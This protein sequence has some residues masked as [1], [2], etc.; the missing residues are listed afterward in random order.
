MI[1]EKITKENLYIYYNSLISIN[2]SSET[3]QN[4]YS[5]YLLRI[6]NLEQTLLLKKCLMPLSDFFDLKES[7]F[8]IREIEENKEDPEKKLLNKYNT[9]KDMINNSEESNKNK[10]LNYNDKFFLQHMLSKKYISIETLPGNNNYNLKLTSN[11]DSAVPFMLKRI[12]ETRKSQEFLT[13]KQSFYMKIY[14]KDKDDDYYINSKTFFIKKSPEYDVDSLLLGQNNLYASNENII[15]NR[16]NKNNINII[17]NNEDKDYDPDNNFINFYENFSELSIDL[18]MNSKY[19]F[20]NQSWYLKYQDKLFSSHIINIIFINSNLYRDTNKNNLVTE[21]EEQLM[22]SAEYIESQ[23]EEEILEQN[24]VPLDSN[25]I[26]IKKKKD[27]LFYY[28]EGKGLISKS[29]NK[30]NLMENQIRVKLV[31]YEKDFYKHVLNNSFWVIEEE[32]NEHKE[33]LEKSP[34]MEG[35]QIKIKNVLLGLYLKVKK[36]GNE[37]EIEEMSNNGDENNINEK[38]NKSLENK[39]EEDE[40]EFELVDEETL[41]KNNFFFSNFKIFHYSISENS[42]Y[43][44]YKGKYALRNIFKDDKKAIDNFDFQELNKYFQPLSINLD[45]EKKYFLLP[46]NED[47]YIF[48]IKKIDI[49]EANHVIYMNKIIKNLDFYLDKCIS[50]EILVNSAIKTINLNLSFF[51]NYLINVEY[52]FRDEN[53]DINEPIEQRQLILENYGVLKIIRKIAEY[54][55]PIARDLNSKKKDIYQTKKYNYNKINNDTSSVFSSFSNNNASNTNKYRFATLN[56][57]IKNRNINI[58]NMKK[59]I[60]IILAFL[61]Y[62]SQDNEE[63][64]EKIFLDLD[65]ILELAEN[66]F[67]LDK[68]NLLNFIFK[69]IKHSEVLQEYITG[70]RLNLM[71]TIKNS[72]HYQNYAEKESQNKLIRMDKILLYIE[73]SNNY[74]YYYKKLLKLNKVKH[75]KEKIKQLIIEHMRKVENE[76][77]YKYNYKRNLINII[78][79]TKV[80]LKRIEEPLLNK[81]ENNYKLVEK[82]SDKNSLRNS[83]KSDNDISLLNSENSKKINISTSEE[84]SQKNENEI[85]TTKNA[86]TT[87]NDE[88][89]K[90]QRNEESLKCIKLFLSFFENF[91]INNTLFIQEKC[92]NEFFNSFNEIKNLKKDLNF[93]INGE[94]ESVQLI[95]GIK[96]DPNSGLGQLIPFNLFNKF[97]PKFRSRNINFNNFTNAL[98]DNIDDDSED[99]YYNVN[100]MYRINEEADNIDDNNINNNNIENNNMNHF[101]KIVT[102]SRTMKFNMQHNFNIRTMS[103]KNKKVRHSKTDPNIIK[104]QLTNFNIDDNLLK[105]IE[106]KQKDKDYIKLNKYLCILYTTYQFCINEYHESLL[107]VMN[108]LNNY[109]NNYES[110]CDMKVFENNLSKIKENLITKIAFI[111]NDVLTN[112]YSATKKK[113][114]TLLKGIFDFNNLLVPVKDIKKNKFDSNEDNLEFDAFLLDD[115]KNNK[116]ASNKI[117]DK[118]G[119]KKAYQSLSPEEITLVK[120]LFNFCKKYDKISYIMDK[121]YYFKRI[122]KLINNDLDRPLNQFKK[123]DTLNTNEI[124]TLIIKN[125]GKNIN[126]KSLD[127]NTKYFYIKEFYEIIKDLNEKRKK[128]LAAYLDI[129]NIKKFLSASL[130]NQNDN[131]LKNIKPTAFAYNITKRCDIIIRL[132]M[133]YEIDNI[134]GKLIYLDINHNP[135]YLESNILSNLKRVQNNF[136]EIKNEIKKIKIDFNRRGD[137]CF[138]IIKNENSGIINQITFNDSDFNKVHFEIVNNCLDKMSK[139]FINFLNIDSNGLFRLKNMS[140]LNKI[141]YKENEYFYKKIGFERIMQNLIESINCF[142]DFDRNPIIKLKYCQE[143]LR[144]FLDIQGVYKNFKEIIPTYFTL[145]YKMIIRSLHS[146]ILF[147]DNKI[148]KEEEKYFLKICYYCCESLMLIIFNSEKNFGEL[149]SFM[150]DVFSKLL[151]IYSHLKNPKYRIIFQIL[152]TYYISRVLLFISKEKN[153]DDFSYNSFFNNVYPMNKMKEQISSCIDEFEKNEEEESSEE[154]EESEEN[155]ESEGSREVSENQDNINNQNNNINN[156]KYNKKGIK[157]MNEMS[158]NSENSIKTNNYDET[159]VFWENDE[160]KE[161]FCFYLN[162]L[163]IYILYIHDRN[164]IKKLQENRSNEKSINSIEYNYKN[165]YSKIQKLLDNSTQQN[166]LK[167]QYF[168]TFKLS[169]LKTFNELSLK[170]KN[171]M[172][173]INQENY[174]KNIRNKKIKNNFQFESVLI[175][176]II[177]Y[178]YRLKNQNIEIAVKNR[179]IKRTNDEIISNAPSDDKTSS[180]DGKIMEL[181]NHDMITFYYYDNE[182]IDLILLEKICNDIN[183]GENLNFYCTEKNQINDFNIYKEDLLKIILEMKKEYKLI[184][185]YYKGEYNILHDQYINNDIEKFIILLKTRFTNNDFN[186]IYSMKKF[187]YKK[188]NEI[189]S[190]DLYYGPDTEIYYNKKILSFVEQFKLIENISYKKK[191]DYQK[192]EDFQKKQIYNDFPLASYLTSLIY[193]YPKYPKKTCVFYYKEGFKLLNQRCKREE[194]EKE[195]KKFDYNNP[196]EYQRTSVKE[197]ITHSNTKAHS[198]EEKHNELDKIIEGFILLFSRKDN[199]N[200]IQEEDDFF[201]MINSLTSFIKELKSLDLYLMKRGPLI[202]RLFTVLDFVFDHLFQDFE[203]IINFMKSAENQKLKDKFRKKETNLKIIIIFISTILSLQKAGDNK[204][205]TNN[206]IKFIQNLTGQIIKLLLILI[207]IGK[208]DSMKTADMLLDF[209]YFFIEG[210]NINNLNSLFDYGYFNLVTFIITKIDYYKIFLNNINRVNLHNFID[211][212][213]KIEQKILKIFF[214]YYNVAYNDGKNVGEYLKV[215]EWYEKNYI[216]IKIK[217]KKLYHFS[218]VE[219]EKRSFDIDDALIYKKKRD[220]YSDKELFLRAG[221]PNIELNKITLEDKLNSLLDEDNFNE[222]KIEED[223]YNNNNSNNFINYNENKNAETDNIYINERMNL[224]DSDI[225]QNYNYNGDNSD[226]PYRDDDNYITNKRNYCIIKFDLIL[227]YYSLNIYYKDI[228][229][230]EYFQVNAPTDSFLMGILKFCVELLFFIKD[231]IF[232]IPG[233]IIYLYRRV[234]EKAKPKVQLLQELN[235]IDEDIQTINEKEMFLDLNSKIKCVEITINQILYKIYFPLI[236]KAKIIEEKQDYYLHVGNDDLPDYISYL[237]RNYDKIHIKVTKNHYF[238]KL[239]EIPFLNL[240]FKNISLIGLLLIILAIIQNFLILLSYS[241]FTNESE[242]DCGDEICAFERRRLYCPRF[243]YNENNS[244]TQLNKALRVIGTLELILQIILIFDYIFRNFSIYY[245]LSKNEYIIKRARITKQTED[246]TLTFWE[247]I[248]IIFRSIWRYFTFQL[249]YYILY[250]VFNLLGHTKHPFF[251]AFSL[252][253]LLNRVEVMLSVLKAMYVPGIYILINLFMFLMLEYLF[254]L[255]SLSIFTSHFPNI[256]DSKNFLQTFMRMLDQTFKQDGGIGTYLDQS[257]DPDYVQYSP[258]AYAGGRYWFD[259]IFYICIILIIFQI[260]TSI[261]IDYFMETRKNIEDFSKKSNTECLICGL[262]RELL[263]KLYSN[264]KDSFNKHTVYCHHIKN[265][266]NYLFYVQSLYYRDPII[267]DVIWS[268]H[269]ENNNIY[270]P[271]DTCFQLEERRIEKKINSRKNKEEEF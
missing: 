56:E 196:N 184:T 65:I 199:R 80:I 72:K 28:D 42:E 142:Y 7:L 79:R 257:L 177:L 138:K 117:K 167:E 69:L 96:L 118:N 228:I 88:I 155:N 87:K 190:D 57:K 53:Y 83:I 249:L 52:I 108:M 54:L 260:F 82:E 264:V 126:E 263:E 13:F 218:K 223:I 12:H 141:L 102:K 183:L 97:F 151:K 201:F 204:L 6:E 25:E 110:F 225:S 242:C 129:N 133:K 122:K 253:E 139:N 217:L 145:Y 64:K 41:I 214:V 58:Y 222:T 267:E 216:N 186:S 50:N 158:N 68:S 71:F 187:L 95:D 18:K 230:E 198:T 255:F 29:F 107:T 35:T 48:E 67:I 229:N 46:K 143:V 136:H 236:N 193:L 22:L 70:G 60:T 99:D 234:R 252:L 231:I 112:L 188:M 104:K 150:I 11:I 66:V 180:S 37:I 134:F 164:S 89:L 132:I 8:F 43:M 84:Q 258:K 49:F 248:K 266:I 120:S 159:E 226:L 174:E 63:I 3:N 62:L 9:D 90:N 38:N 224:N 233:L 137:N 237:I 221:L 59:V 33:V 61:T 271:K 209:I 166:L 156:N 2:T 210:P 200:I 165:L 154:G 51:I 197:T 113:K 239:S 219:M 24:Q 250:I 227:C 192:K 106:Q 153:Y 172:S 179:R 32:I 241:D 157:K 75:K 94:N 45:S 130:K 16:K 243:F 103:Y 74:L 194:F 47:D 160:E 175:E 1:K 246:I 152:Y 121:I 169:N 238:D 206:I 262:K 269:L 185:S 173:T 100:D 202:T 73:T 86:E 268:Y 17:N 144:V 182:F 181:R 212:Y 171:D 21:K 213:A 128:I 205:L 168:D 34:L 254:S 109:F 256:K 163:S 251:Y 4:I 116:G 98:D 44:T 176:A 27:D 124:V 178:K 261:I 149:R 93:L 85:I 123:F 91:D 147:Q 135:I 146:I 76:Y 232:S 125:E 191:E 140:E 245:T 114:P 244:Y 265:Y 115:D 77:K 148:G 5:K 208:E 19:T 270:L 189:Y 162:Y 215:R 78:N 247:Y 55:L 81:T 119:K 39:E 40:Y 259:L 30:K 105:E 220:D 36:K 10:R 26:K 195:Q 211:N 240:L 131:N 203:K 31:P 207:E 235:K 127:Q 101:N 14:I 92:Y 15:F 20:L 170:I 111:N 161:K 23:N